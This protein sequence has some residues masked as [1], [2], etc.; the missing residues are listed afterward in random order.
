MLGLTGIAG[1]SVAIF[2][3]ELSDAG[4]VDV[5]EAFRDHAVVFFL[6][7]ARAVGRGRDR[8]REVTP[9]SSSTSW[10]G[11][12]KLKQRFGSKTIRDI[13]FDVC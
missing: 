1:M 3:G 9:K 2:E 11:L 7:G 13:R 12:R 10:R 4:C 6:V 5:A 8:A